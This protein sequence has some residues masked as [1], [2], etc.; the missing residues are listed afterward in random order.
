MPRDT[1]HNR[2]QVSALSKDRHHALVLTIVPILPAVCPGATGFRTGAGG[3]GGM[4]ACG[5]SL[6]P[7]DG[8]LPPPGWGFALAVGG[9]VLPSRFGAGG[10]F[11]TGGRSG[12]LLPDPMTG[13]TGRTT[14]TAP[15]AAFFMPASCG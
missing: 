14:P 3:L 12:C 8:V 4:L 10:R 15:M 11:S 1:F 13:E 5:A 6:P 9:G 7:I 2:E